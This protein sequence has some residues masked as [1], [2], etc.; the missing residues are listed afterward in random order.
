M[1]KRSSK[2]AS[3]SNSSALG[4]EATLWANADKLRSGPSEKQLE[5]LDLAG[6]ARE[7]PLACVGEWIEP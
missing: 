2:P 5:K 4:F 3:R 6:F 7:R 1:A